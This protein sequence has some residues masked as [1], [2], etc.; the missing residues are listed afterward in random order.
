M[1]PPDLD[2][3]TALQKKKFTHTTQL[4]F[5]YTHANS[6]LSI[7]ERHTKTAVIDIKGVGEA[8]RA[9]L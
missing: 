1:L 6:T 4:T 8:P 5:K 2:S 9:N 7:W 3:H